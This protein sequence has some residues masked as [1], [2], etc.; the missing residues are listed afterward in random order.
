MQASI[1]ASCVRTWV[2]PVSGTVRI[3]SRVMKEWYSQA[4]GSPQRVRIL[5][6][7]A[8]IW[9]ASGWAVAPLNDLVGVMHDLTLDVAAGDLIRFVLDRQTFSRDANICFGDRWT[10]FGPCEVTD[11]AVPTT[12]MDCIP[13]TLSVG[14]KQLARHDVNVAD[15]LL[16]LAPLLGG[17]GDKRTAYV[18][19][20]I[21]VTQTDIYQLGIDLTGWHTAWL[22]GKG[23]SDT[24][25]GGNDASTAN[26]EKHRVSVQIEAGA[27]AELPVAVGAGNAGVARAGVGSHQHD[28]VLRGEPLRAGLDHEGFF[29]AGEPG[30]V[31]QY[32]HHLAFFDWRVEYRKLHR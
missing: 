17:A 8:Q 22:D 30:Q 26:K 24:S 23:L 32:R 7:K 21:T 11:P 29:G 12:E 10:V 27:M 5:H 3:V 18:F 2:A 15:G 4:V 31:E 9:P 16:D 13:A 25:I 28:A 19:I 20:P 14:V 1:D 6:G